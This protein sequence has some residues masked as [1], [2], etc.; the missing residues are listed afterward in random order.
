MHIS[1]DPNTLGRSIVPDLSILSEQRSAISDI[2]DAVDG[3]LTKDRIAKIRASRLA[4][5]S[6]LT[7]QLNQ[8][9]EVALRA[10]FDNSPLI[11]ERVGYELQ[12]ALD[13]DAVIVPELGTEYY[14][15]LR[16]LTLGGSNKQKIGRTKGSALGWGMAAAFGVNVAL[17]ERQVVAVAGRRRI[18][19]QPVGN[20]VEHRPL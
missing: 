10:R 7:S 3:M 13:K 16:Q 9:R 11:W 17:P 2:S 8:T 12:Q 18:P 5:V 6:A 19:L 4:E 1:H 14:K 15:L 20:S